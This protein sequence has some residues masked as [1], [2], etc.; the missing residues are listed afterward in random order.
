MS[1]PNNSNLDGFLV[2]K[3][4]FFNGTDFNYWNTRMNCYLK[5]IDYD[6]QYIVTHGDMIPMKKVNNR[7]VEKTHE[8]FD[9]RDKIMISSGC[10]RNTPF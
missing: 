10:R 6:I 4:L 7:F 5:S 3:P 9:E 1:Q 8:D 2:I